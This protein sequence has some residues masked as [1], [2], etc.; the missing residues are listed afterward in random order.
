MARELMNPLGISHQNNLLIAQ[1]VVSGERVG[2]AQI[3]S[4]GYAGVG[5]D[6]SRFEDDGDGT[7]DGSSSL[8]RRDTQSA[9]SIE[10]D[11]DEQMWEEFE[12]DG[13]DFP[14]GLASLPWTNNYKAAF[15]AADSR[16]KRRDRMV[17]EELNSRP[18][19]W[20]LSSVYV[21]PKYRKQGIGS[22]LVKQVLRRHVITNKRGRDIYALTLAK[23]VPWYEQFGF[24]IEEKVPSSMTIEMAVGNVITKLIREKLVCIRTSL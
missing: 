6:P 11:I 21:I 23:T 16:L 9:L 24:K 13:V 12:S 15:K 8:K 19:F 1:D 18:M 3:R 17:N 2:W 5:L 10:R 4:I 7:D 22:E 14:T 20:E